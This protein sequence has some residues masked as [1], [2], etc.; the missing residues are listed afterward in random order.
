MQITIIKKNKLSVFSLPEVVQGNYWITDYENGKKIN[1]LNVEAKDGKWQLVSNQDA[2][3]T[4]KDGIMVPYAELKEYTFRMVKNNYK[5]ESY[6]LYCSP[7]YD[8][9]YKEYSIP[10][11]GVVTVGSDTGASITYKLG[12]IPL[13]AC[14][15]LKK[16]GS[17][18]VEIVG[19]TSVYVNQKMVV[20]SKK[21][22]YGDVIFI[23]GLKIILMKKDGQ[24]Y[25]LV[26]NP[27]GLVDYDATFTNIVPVK[28][29]FVDK[30]EELSDDTHS[31]INY[32]YRTPYFYKLLNKSTYSIDTP[33]GKHEEDKTPAMLTVGPMITM[34]MSSVIMLMSNISQVKNGQTDMRQT[35]TSLAMSGGMLVSSLLWP[36][37]TRAY[38]KRTIKKDEK[39]RQKLYKNYIDSIE[40]H[41]NSDLDAQRRSLFENNMSVTD[42]QKIIKEHDI[43]LW[44][45]RVTDDNFLNLP[46][47]IGNLPMQIEIK[48]P[49]E[50]FSLSQ[51]NLLDIARE[52]GKKERILNDV[53]V[54]FSFK[55]NIAAGIVGNP[56]INKE[57]VDRIVLQMMTNYSYDELKIVTF[58]SNDNEKEWEYMKVLPHSWNNDRSFRFFGSNN[59]EYREIM[60]VLEK[61]YNERRSD[62]R[63]EE[64]YATHYTIITDAP[65]S[66]DSYDFI[67]NV[68]ASNKY[69][70]FNVI[71]LVDKVSA[72]PNECKN[73]IQVD[74]NECAIFSSVLN[75]A[76]QTFKI[77]FSSTDDLFECA[78]ELSNIP[79]DIKTEVESNL[80]DVYHFLEMYQVG[81]VEQLNVFERWRRNNPI[82]SLAAPI[83]IGKGGEVINLDLHE[84]YHGPHG[85]IAGTTGSGKSEFI[86]SYILSLAVNYHPNEVQMILIDYKGGSLTGA[87]ANDMYYLPHLAGTITNLDGNEL[88]RSLAS[89]ESEVKRRQREFNEARNLANE[90][91]MDIYKYQKLYR[92]GRLKGKD[93]IAHLFIISDEFAELKEQQPEF[94]DKLISVARVGRSLGVHLILATQKPGGVVDQQI[95]SN[96]RFRVC[97]KVQEPSDSQEVIKKPDAAYLQKRGRFYLQVGTDEVYTLGQSTWTGGQYIPSPSFRKERNT[98]VNAINNIGFV[99]TTKDVEVETTGESLGEE[100]PNV[101]KYICATAKEKKIKIKKLWLEKIPEKI[102]IDK[103]KE[104]YEFTKTEYYLNPII[105]EYDDPDNQEQN[106]LTVPLSKLG[107]ALVFGITGSGKEDFLSS[108]IYSCIS[109]YTS[110]EVNFYIVDFGSETLRVFRNAPHVGDV[111]FLNDVDKLNNLFKMIYG[112]LE[113]R[114][115]EFVEYGGTYEDYI[116]RSEKKVPNLVI[117]VN[118]YEVFSE[119]YEDLTEEIAKLSREAFKYGIY[120]VITANSEGAVRSRVRQNFN[121]TYVLQLNGDYDYSSILG[122]THGKVP[123]KIKGRGLFKKDDIYEFQTAII[124][125]ENSMDY[126]MEYTKELN[127][128]ASYK[129]KQVPVLPEVVDYEYA[130]DIVEKDLKKVFIGVNKNTLEPAFL[131]FEKQ[132]I[133]LVSSQDVE[134][135]N[136]FVSALVKELEYYNKF[137]ICFVNATDI[138]FD[139]FKSSKYYTSEFNELVEKYCE[140]TQKVSEAYE[141]SGFSDKFTET[142][143]KHVIFIFGVGEFLNKLSDD[144]KKKFEEIIHNNGTVKGV[145]FVLIDNADQLKS[146]AYDDWFKNGADTTKGVWVGSGVADQNLLRINRLTREAN[147]EIPND[148]GYIVNSSKAARVKLLASFDEK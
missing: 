62:N 137:N 97:L 69:Y 84:K 35:I 41:I 15:I 23:F 88:N 46:V 107:N 39:T 87:F 65:K 51:D 130:K 38:Q 105:G 66:I 75:G 32:F 134:N 27:A 33:P 112:E 140:Y 124:K 31:E 99:T 8:K 14:S 74:K 34:S 86:I 9:T 110:N 98:A 82:L 104:K 52:L 101:V 81:K 126:I 120:F 92:E 4:D 77:D 73:F 127:N 42:C 40:K 114:K 43:K 10:A 17:Y 36:M 100:L 67:K 50:H 102:Y 136:I 138:A 123:S 108:L 55:D 122:N 1:L 2:F 143:K 109:S 61:I 58:T 118:N 115:K 72:L 49:E 121:L 79:I 106:V 76:T 56:V 119:N 91:T 53:P 148:F 71:M 139:R 13:E 116:K 47:G 18:Y 28:S 103:L 54:S 144:N 147:E 83:G 135:T 26:N 45:R 16:D 146:Y 78:K 64:K 44:Q 133:N 141:K 37:I 117:I 3:I 142:L 95:W 60:Y 5:N 6:Y 19:N 21:I 57:F 96:T 80:P 129:A 128:S 93:P 12:G 25:L 63:S 111:I 11:S 70:G 131:N 89:I 113:K 94:M 29:D 90:S 20:G 30:N 145:Y 48:Y 85:L 7:V 22:E 125:E 132:V 68:M 59:D 24:D